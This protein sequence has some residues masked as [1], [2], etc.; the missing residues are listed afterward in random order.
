MLALA[1]AAGLSIAASLAD[2]D[3]YRFFDAIGQL[4][5]TGPT[6]TNVCDLQL[7]IIS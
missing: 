5:K 1:D 6:M 3:S 7:T 2:N 4:F